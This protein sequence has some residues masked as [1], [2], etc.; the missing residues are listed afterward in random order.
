MKKF[1]V[2]DARSANKVGVDGVMVGSWATIRNSDRYILDV[3]CGCGIISLMMAQR[4]PSAYIFGIDVDQDAVT[5]AKDNAATSPWNDRMQIIHTD[6]SELITDMTSG[7]SLP[8][9]FD[10]IISN[11]PFFQ[12][13][14]NPNESS[15]MTARHAGTL[16]PSILLKKSGKLLREFGRLVFIA[17]YLS[18]DKLEDEAKQYGWKILR[19]CVVRGRA[20]LQPKR[21]IFEFCINNKDTSIEEPVTESLTIEESPGIYTSEYIQ[22]GKDFYLNF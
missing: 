6:F 1:E 3:G 13:G 8:R 11:P 2:S 7:E 16:S 21:V 19:K 4:N 17:P 18:E 12:S 20:E 9:K 15:R 10:L 14:V 5:E 22:L